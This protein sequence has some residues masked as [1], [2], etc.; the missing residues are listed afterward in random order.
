MTP[1]LSHPIR[2]G[3]NGFC[4]D[5]AP[6]RTGVER[7]NRLNIHHV[8]TG[9]RIHASA[10]QYHMTEARRR[11][12]VDGPHLVRGRMAV[13]RWSYRTVKFHRVVCRHAVARR[14]CQSHCERRSL[15]DGE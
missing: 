14:C 15:P 6:P 3:F 10:E 1:Q 8:P 9:A 7:I 4:V 13:P 2:L 5:C 12:Q 11:L